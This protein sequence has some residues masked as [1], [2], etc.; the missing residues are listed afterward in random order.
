VKS[1]ILILGVIVIALLAFGGVW[2]YAQQAPQRAALAPTTQT[3]A[4]AGTS[5]FSQVVSSNTSAAATTT[6][7]VG[8]PIAAPSMITVN[9]SSPVTVT[10]QITGVTPI[11]GGVNLLLLGA[12]GTQPT[13]LGVMQSGGNGI[14]T[15]Q[16][17][18]DETTP[19]QIQLE[20]SAAFQGM[21]KRVISPVVQIPV[22]TLLTDTTA[23]FSVAY[24]PNTYLVNNEASSDIYWLDS[25]PEGVAIGGT[26]A[27]GSTESISGFRIAISATPYTPTGSF[28][29]N[30]YLAFDYPG[31]KVASSTATTIGGL[32][33]F[34]MTF[35]DEEGG[36]HPE[37]YIYHD[38]FVFEVDYLS[39]IYINGFSD[40]PGLQTFSEVLQHFTFVP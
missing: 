39:T 10:V 36:G 5:T 4:E 35:A 37:A 33:G 32:P 25:S 2:L 17:A 11:P 27:P 16:H 1:T 24:P 21:L 26:P 14:Y 34:V 28:D 18:F 22:W 19:G 38:G 15:L 13:I 3:P 8:T 30:A 7:T 9:T 12:T 20:V 40:Q 31:R 29:I 23:G 6:A